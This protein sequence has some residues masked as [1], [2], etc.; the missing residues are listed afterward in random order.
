MLL[1]AEKASDWCPGGISGPGR[2]FWARERAL[3][4]T[5]IDMRLWSGT[6]LVTT[7][8]QGPSAQVNTVTQWRVSSPGFGLRSRP[9]PNSPTN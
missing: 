6:R 1:P 9:K 8:K 5:G 4:R 7:S 3:A 2:N